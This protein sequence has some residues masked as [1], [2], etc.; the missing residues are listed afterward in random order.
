MRALCKVL[1]STTLDTIDHSLCTSGTNTLGRINNRDGVQGCAAAPFVFDVL[2]QRP[3]DTKNPFN[4]FGKTPSHTALTT[5][6]V[7]LDASL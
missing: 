6:Q 5:P 7:W 4:W 2:N 3:T 1:Y